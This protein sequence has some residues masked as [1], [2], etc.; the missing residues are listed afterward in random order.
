MPYFVTFGPIRHQESSISTHEDFHR[1]EEIKGSSDRS[2]GL[3]MAAVSGLVA[4]FPLIRGSDANWTFAILAALLLIIAIAMPR[5]LRVPNKWWFRFGLLLGKLTSPIVLGLIYFI[6]ITPVAIGMRLF[7]R[8][9]LRLRLDP[10]A[11][12]YWLE[13]DPPGPAPDSMKNQF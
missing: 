12:S 8:D 11:K 1:E 7:R 10:T 6:V 9:A 4:I 3:V 5:L 2:F 13:R